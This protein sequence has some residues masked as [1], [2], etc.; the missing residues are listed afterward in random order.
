MNN[1]LSLATGDSIVTYITRNTKLNRE[2]VGLIIELRR[3]EYK[4]SLLA[5]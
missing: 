2:K 3:L 1:L 5:D 4:L